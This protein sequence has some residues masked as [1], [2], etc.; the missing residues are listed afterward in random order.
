MLMHH[1]LAPIPCKPWSLSGLSERLIVS[2]Y[3][4]DYGA[5][6][7]SLNAT[8]ADLDALVLGDVPAYQLLAMK[9]EE[10]AATNSVILHELYF[11]SLGGDGGVLF[12][13]SGHGNQILEPIST[14][15]RQA[16]G[17]V[18]KWRQEFASLAEALSHGSGWAVLNYSRRDGRLYN[19]IAVDHSR[20][21]IDAVPLLALDM[22]EHAYHL[23]FGA[24]ASAYIDAFMRNIDWAVIN[25][26]LEVASDGAV[27]RK[28]DGGDAVPSV[29][30][31]ELSAKLATGGPI[32]VLDARP[33]HYFSRS[34]DMMHGASWRDP[35]RIDEWSATLSADEPVFVY[36]AYGYAVGCGVTATLR[37]RGFDA[38]YVRGGLSAWYAAGGERA[39]KP[40]APNSLPSHLHP[41]NTR[42]DLAAGD[43]EKA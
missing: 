12:T 21:M 7:R 2:H 19:H 43:A 25:G 42:A 26:R 30:V 29:S 37:E 27:S 4:N 41:H 28:A 31:E 38:K 9:R 16:F 24:N 17:S 18:V 40:P 23:D 3:E 5:A 11:G 36:C 8:R 34:H 1:A 13:G 35:D 15:L 14:A 33:R 6:V 20:A 32:Q 10:I 39:L 22:Y